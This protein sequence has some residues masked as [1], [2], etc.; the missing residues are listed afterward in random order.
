MV[1]SPGEFSRS[2]GRFSINPDSAKAPITKLLPDPC[3]WLFEKPPIYLR[4]FYNYIR[5]AFVRRRLAVLFLARVD[6]WNV[7]QIGL[8]SYGGPSLYASKEIFACAIF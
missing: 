3:Q 4:L 8:I 6:F 5:T 7:A 2:P 1:S